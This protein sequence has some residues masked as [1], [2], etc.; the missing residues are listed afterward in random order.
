MVCEARMGQARVALLK[1]QTFMNNSGEAV[2]PLIRRYGIEDMSRVVVIH[3]ELDLDAGRLKLK[4]GGGLAG[5]NG[6]KSIKNHL[7]TDKFTRVR[8]GVGRPPGSSSGANYVLGR[9]PKSVWAEVEIAVEKAADA[10]EAIV[11]DG[12]DAA[13]VVFNQK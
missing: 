3:D 5:H 10:V 2:A 6:L 12:V 11:S 13:M 7:G 1:P 9:P 4:L 8:I